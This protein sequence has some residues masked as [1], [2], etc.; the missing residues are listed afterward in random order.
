MQ[1]FNKVKRS[2]EAQRAW[3]TL[4]LQYYPPD[5]DPSKGSLNAQRGTHALGARAK[6]LSTTGELVVRFELPFNIWCGSCEAH[7]GAGVRYNAKKRKVGAYHST[8]IYA[9]RCKCHLCD[10]FFEIRTDP[11]VR[12]FHFFSY[13][14]SSLSC[15]SDA[16]CT[17]HTLCRP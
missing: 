1:G 15:G 5:Y 13:I 6:N 3:L 17:E 7:L 11:Q 8:P 9:F 10:G 2:N 14:C 4:C 12:L 16:R